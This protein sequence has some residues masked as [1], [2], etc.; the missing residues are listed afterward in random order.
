[1]RS[2][3]VALAFL[4]IVPI[5]FR[6]PLADRDIARS[7]L[8]YPHVGL[9]V[10]ALLGLLVVWVA[11]LASPWVGAFGV[12]AAWVVVT[13]GLHL[14][15]F[16]DLCDGLFGGQNAD[17][18]LKIMKDPQVGAFGMVGVVLLLLGKFAVL[19]ELLAQQSL[20]APWLV[21]TA[22]VVARCLV[23]VMMAGAVYPRAEG[24]GRWVI[25]SCQVW[26]GWL[27]AVIALGASV[28]LLPWRVGLGAA[29][30]SLAGVGGLRF[31]CQQR[32]GGVT[33]DC[34]GAGIEMAELVFLMVGYLL[35]LTG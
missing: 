33:G 14:D 2:F 13:G 5:R 7:R 4:T 20:Q 31:L 27:F 23:L 11:R 19:A 22:A 25:T 34:L 3:L 21:A 8:W 10:A 1:M 6:Q 16:C 9:I 28:L 18:R 12:L 32:L 17:E 35:L 15:G 24:T 29:L 26:E 30:A